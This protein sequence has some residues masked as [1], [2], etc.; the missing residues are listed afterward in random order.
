MLRDEQ[1]V[2]DL[3]YSHVLQVDKNRFLSTNNAS[4]DIMNPN[5]RNLRGA[6]I[7]L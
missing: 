3:M 1:K 2:I 4:R 7:L 5:Y 6:L